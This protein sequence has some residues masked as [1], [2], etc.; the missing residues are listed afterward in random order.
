MN[1]WIARYVQA[2]INRLPEKERFEVERELTCNI[3][4]MLSD[5]PNEE[6]IKSVLHEMGAPADLAEEYRQ[7][8]QYLLSPRVYN[9]YLQV[10]KFLVPTIGI[11]IA[12]IG[13]VIGGI[14]SS[15]GN[16]AEV[17]SLVSKIIQG[18]FQTGLGMGF[19]AAFQALFWTTVGFVIAE[20]TGAFSDSTPHKDWQLTDLP[21]LATEKKISIAESVSEMG[22]G[23]FFSILIL[24][25]ALGQLPIAFI[26]VD[27]SA[28]S[29]PLFS[30][31]FIWKLVPVLVI[32]ILLTILVNGIK[33]KDRRWTKRV[34]QWTIFDSLVPAILW[35][36]LFLQPDFFSP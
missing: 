9:E 31:T 4:D 7:E 33:L 19:T 20:R 13:G 28:S 24:L 12:I 27:N 14:E 30:Q 32:G 25:E 11:L 36:V 21:P 8:P 18:I 23:L 1:D 10:I 17:V 34:M 22:F 2:V 35:I 6:E 29:I 3:Y 16:E 5:N 15:K 26:K